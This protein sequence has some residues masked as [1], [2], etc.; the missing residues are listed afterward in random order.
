MKMDSKVQTS[1]HIINQKEGTLRFSIYET[2]LIKVGTAY[3]WLWVKIELVKKEI[4][5]H[6]QILYS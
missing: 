4:F 1:K 6:Y 3:I 5:L 2:L